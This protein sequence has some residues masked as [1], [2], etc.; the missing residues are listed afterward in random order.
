ML[1]DHMIVMHCAAK[2]WRASAFQADTGHHLQEQAGHREI[3]K[4]H[5]STGKA[6]PKVLRTLKC[7]A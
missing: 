4:Y 5:Q 3:L 2:A 7:R 1:L 6:P